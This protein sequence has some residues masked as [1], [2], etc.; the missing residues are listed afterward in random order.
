MNK[1]FKI[2]SGCGYSKVIFKNVTEDGE[3]RQYCQTCAPKKTA[4]SLKKTPKRLVTRSK[5]K[6]AQDR[7]YSSKRKVYLIKHPLC[8]M[9][10]H[11][12]TNEA[13]EIHHAA[14]RTGD[15]Y[16]NEET[17]F[18]TCNSCHKWVHLNPKEAR[19]LGF[20]K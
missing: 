17:W 10:I 6:Q 1:T 19:E 3:R 4:V 11:N 20:L 12:C 8:Q 13:T 16:L 2:C 14:Y 18:A 7:I 5:S 15:N 9:A